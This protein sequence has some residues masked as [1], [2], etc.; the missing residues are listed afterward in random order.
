MIMPST[1]VVEVFEEYDNT[2]LMKWQ[3][4]IQPSDVRVAFETISDALCATSGFLCVVVDLTQNPRFPLSETM[5]NALDCYRHPNL[6]AWLILGGGKAA[7]SIEGFL[8]RMTGKQ[9]VYWFETMA[10]VL[11]RL[12]QMRGIQTGEL[13]PPILF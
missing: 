2:L 10:D 8:S 7:R 11:E 6:E 5:L 13:Q 12:Q 3:H 9:N 4:D 1:V